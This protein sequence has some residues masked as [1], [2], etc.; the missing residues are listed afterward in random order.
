[1]EEKGEGV[2]VYWSCPKPK[3]ENISVTHPW[4]Y[5]ND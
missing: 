4:Y 1:M 3:A 5:K 2:M